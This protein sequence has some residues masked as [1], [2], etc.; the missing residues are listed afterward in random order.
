M[1]EKAIRKNKNELLSLINGNGRRMNSFPL[2]HARLETFLFI[3]KKFW[4]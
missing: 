2:K 3:A 4:R 1:W